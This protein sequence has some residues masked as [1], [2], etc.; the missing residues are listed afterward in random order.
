MGQELD[1]IRAHYGDVREEDRLVAGVGALERVRTQDVIRRYAAT[2]PA[3]VLDVGGGPGAY[4]TWLVQ[5]GYDVDLVD[6]VSRHVE[7]ARTALATAGPGQGRAHMGE[8]RARAFPDGGFDLVLLL[9]PLYHLLHAEDRAAALA[10][11]RRVLRPGGVLIAAAISR[12]ASVMDG[13][14]RALVRDPKFVSLMRRDLEEGRH[15]NPTDNPVYFTTAYLH[16]PE[17]LADEARR[18][19]FRTQALVGVEGPFWCMPGFAELWEDA[20]TRALMLEVLAR[21]ESEPS[22]LGASA[23]LLLV[24]INPDSP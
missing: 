2:P 4:A 21:V 11:A 22:L 13:F 14:S 7:Q 23:H 17:D 16:R 15:I 9:G 10:E 6:P 24:A 8:A 19:G 18:A 3:R 20:G 5:R 12:F 1:D